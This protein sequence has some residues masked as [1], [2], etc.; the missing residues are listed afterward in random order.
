MGRPESG[1]GDEAGGTLRAGSGSRGRRRLVVNADDF[2]RSPSINDAVLRAHRDGILTTASLMVTGEAFDEAVGIARRTPTLGV[3]LHLTLVQGTSVLPAARLPGLVG[4]DGRFL[5]AAPL[6]GFRY[7]AR[8]DLRE[9]LRLELAAQLERFRSTGLRLDHVNG[10]LHL[11]L[12]PV[13]FDL[14]TGHALEWGIDRFRLTRESLRM[15]LEVQRGRWLYRLSHALIFSV[16]AR[17]AGPVLA[18]LG[19]RHTDAVYGLLADG[20][21]D[22]AYLLR[23]LPRLPLG[24]VELYSH[25]SMGR[26]RHELD[27]LVSPR[28]RRLVESLGFERVRY[29]DL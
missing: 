2:G 27:A 28:V 20:G 16:L 24:D 23:L 1:S 17:Q 11:H 7:W 15:S 26:F 21:V 13:V 22:E 29:Q 5:E 3:G 18:R 10:H 6:A 12:H 25:P 9:P 8:R 19:I 4:S 14:L